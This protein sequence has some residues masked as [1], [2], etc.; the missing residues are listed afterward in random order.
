MPKLLYLLCTSPCFNS[1]KLGMIDNIQRETLSSTLNGLRLDESLSQASLPVLGIILWA[2]CQIPGWFGPIDI[3][4]IYP[5]YPTSFNHF[6][7][8]CL[9]ECYSHRGLCIQVM[10]SFGRKHCSQPSVNSSSKG[11]GWL[12]LQCSCRVLIAQFSGLEPHTS[13]CLLCSWSRLMATCL[14]LGS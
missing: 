8:H 9:L 10:A 6:S 1:E 7:P 12:N 3:S 2:G 4:F 5:S 11:L 13:P 14:A